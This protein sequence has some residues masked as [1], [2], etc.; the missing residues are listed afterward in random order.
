MLP[1]VLHFWCEFSFPQLGLLYIRSVDISTV[2]SLLWSIHLGPL[3]N[4]FSGKQ[5][6]ISLV[7][8]SLLIVNFS[9]LFLPGSL[10][11]NLKL[12]IHAVTS[13]QHFKSNCNQKLTASTLGAKDWRF[14]LESRDNNRTWRLGEKHW[15]QEGRWWWEV[16]QGKE[17]RWLLPLGQSLHV[18]H[19]EALGGLTPCECHSNHIF[20]LGSRR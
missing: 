2:S 10:W 18:Q 11:G 12:F 14:L 15:D 20:L 3:M 8:K 13:P 5:H 7:F 19:H 16:P 6:I 1:L 9:K 4:L 17:G